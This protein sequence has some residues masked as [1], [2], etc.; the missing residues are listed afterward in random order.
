METEDEEDEDEEDGASEIRRLFNRQNQNVPPTDYNE[1]PSV[2]EDPAFLNSPD[3]ELKKYCL[4]MEPLRPTDAIRQADYLDYLCFQSA[5][6]PGK[7][8]YYCLKMLAPYQVEE[9]HVFD[10]S[11]SSFNKPVYG[12]N[13]RKT[14]ILGELMGAEAF[15]LFTPIADEEEGLKIPQAI[16][17]Y[18]DWLILCGVQH[19]RQRGAPL[20]GLYTT[21][22][23]TNIA[24]LKHLPIP[25][26][27]MKDFVDQ[28]IE[29]AETYGSD[30]VAYN[31]FVDTHECQLFVRR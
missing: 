5:E 9:G 7:T 17:N 13:N 27:L 2:A 3:E 18:I 12:L 28:M 16:K 26:E 29:M 31:S 14:F 4:P 11:P 23:K 6:F 21:T 24:A 10:L 1:F 30:N 19:V 20:P 8:W 25:M 15:L 22:E